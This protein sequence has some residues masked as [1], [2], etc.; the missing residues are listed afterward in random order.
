MVTLDR[1]KFVV[2][3]AGAFVLAGLPLAA[4][5]E[6][7]V[8]RTLPV[9][10][11]VADIAV[12]HGDVATAQAAIDAALDELRRVDRVMTRFTTASEI[13]RANASA[14]REAVLVSA[15]TAGVVRDA[16]AWAEAT[17]G[18]F[19][20]AIGRAVALW[21]VTSRTTPPGAHAVRRLAGRRLYRSLDLGGWRGQPAV[22]FADRDV[23][24][25]LGGIAKGYAVDRAAGALRARG[26]ERAL[27][28]VGGDLYALGEMERGSGWRVGI[29]APDEPAR[30]VEALTVAD[31]AI[32]TSGDY[33]QFFEHAG[34]RYH[35]LLDPRTGEPRRTPVRSVTIAAAT[36]MDADAAATAA[37]GMSRADADRVLARRA[38][39][40]RVVR[41]IDTTA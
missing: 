28:N 33:F 21:D 3:G 40:A 39:G 41:T 2:L 8:R 36:C 22:R 12:V 4:R 24:I 13:G 16:L 23:A 14:A 19:D 38:P 29:Q 17:D 10:G 34:R 9:M 30:I 37:F 1:R 18:A 5:R 7:I 27:V 31:Q 35:H 26:I 32:A 25:D 20:P 6:R 11:T 15:E